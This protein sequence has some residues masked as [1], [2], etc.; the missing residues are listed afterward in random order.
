MTEKQIHSQIC[1]YLKLKYPKVIFNTDMSG[2]K[3]T[4]GQAVQANKLR[5]NKGFPDICIYETSFDPF[6][7]YSALFLE[8]KKESPYLK[9]GK[10][11]TNKHIQE[12]N[13]VHQKLREKGYKVEFVWS[14]EDA[15]KVFDNYIN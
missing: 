8:V 6:G 11:S 10:L 7:Y 2:I 13:K 15:I 3:L 12:Q 1:N 4:I 5:S 14:L 9:S